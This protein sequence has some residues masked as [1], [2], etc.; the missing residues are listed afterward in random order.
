M[1]SSET[2]TPTPNQDASGRFARGNCGGPGNPLEAGR[3]AE[4]R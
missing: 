4:M 3:I 1:S 2:T